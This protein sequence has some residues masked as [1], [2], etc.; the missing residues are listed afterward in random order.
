MD[1]KEFTRYQ[2]PQSDKETLKKLEG[3]DK[4]EKYEQAKIGAKRMDAAS[5][6]QL[7]SSGKAAQDK[8]K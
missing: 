5:M 3:K 7:S 4:A 1:K 6:N 2:Q 8:R